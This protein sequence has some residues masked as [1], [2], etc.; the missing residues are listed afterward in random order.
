MTLRQYLFDVTPDS[1]AL[2]TTNLKSVDNVAATTVSGGT[3]G[4]VRSTTANVFKG[5]AA[6]RQ[7]TGT[8]AMNVRF[9]F[10]ATNTKGAVSVYRFMATLP[11]ATI[12]PIDIRD[13]S[14]NALFRIS[15]N[16]SGKVL[17][18]SPTG[19]TLATSTASITPNQW[20]RYEIVFDIGSSSTTGSAT[21][22]VYNGDATGT[23]DVT[24]TATGV[25]LG[26][27]ANPAGVV[28]LGMMQAVASVQQDWDVLQMNDGATSM[29]GPYTTTNVLPT[30]SITPTKQDVSAGAS[31]SATVAA[32]DSD[33]TIASYAWTITRYAAGAA[34]AAVT[35]TS[36]AS[37][38]TV[39]WTAGPAG[40]LDVAVCDVVDNSGGHASPSP[41]QEV[42]VA[43]T[44]DVT[45]LGGT[46][47]GD[48][49][50]NVGGASSGGVALADASDATYVESPAEVATASASRWRLQPMGPRTALTLTA[51]TVLT[52]T[53]GTVKVRLREGKTAQTLRQEWDVTQQA[54][55]FAD[56]ALVVSSPGS[57]SDW[58]DLWI[59][60]S[61]ST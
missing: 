3:G 49:W 47:A 5:T 60:F 13:N 15:I 25:N 48:T 61:E 41:S 21:V 50:S 9:P 10:V 14:G 18:Q 36:G 40:T 27:G 1:T 29:I 26:G 54:T 43:A 7:I 35:P 31:V 17:I 20:N 52:S 23:P 24:V 56:Q 19:A 34:P 57:I 30:A 12:N 51:R 38:A 2:N 16:T 45:T 22:N 33:G 11:S 6:M 8:G 32:S 46:N 4:T 59:E 42:R 28:D 37:S 53:G 39:N 55:G 44:G 58:G